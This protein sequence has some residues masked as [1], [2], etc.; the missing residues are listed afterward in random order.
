MSKKLTLTL[1][2]QA[3]IANSLAYHCRSEHLPCPTWQACPF[4]ENCEQVQ[5][6]HW[7]KALGF[8][9]LKKVNL[10][11]VENESEAEHQPL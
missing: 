11:E 5:G 9:K 1:D 7:Q 8:V 4:D 3:R 6:W 10:N 2:T